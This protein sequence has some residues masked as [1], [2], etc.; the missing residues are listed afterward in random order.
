MRHERVDPGAVPVDQHVQD[1]AL[2]EAVVGDVVV[3]DV[4]AE[5]PAREQRIAVLAV[6][7]VG[8]GAVGHVVALGRKVR[9]LRRA[10][11][12]DVR[13]GE[14]AR[15]AV[16][17]VAHLLEEDEVGVQRF[18]AEADVVDLQALARPDAAHALVDVVG[19]HAQ[20]VRRV[21]G[22][23]AG[24]SCHGVGG[25]NRGNWRIASALEGEKQ[26]SAASRQSSHS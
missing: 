15:L 22:G 13:V 2:L 1:A 8:I 10:R 6:V 4:R 9:G 26:R 19:G 21:Q 5:R 24:A 11:P 20:D 14:A 18:D 3:A 12:A 17:E 23:G 25:V 16:V 7:R